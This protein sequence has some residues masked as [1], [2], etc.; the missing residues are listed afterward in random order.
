MPTTIDTHPDLEERSDDELHD[1]LMHID[2]SEEPGRY[3]AAR[4]EFIRRHGASIQ[5]RGVDEY[6]AQ[7]RRRP[8]FA[9]RARFRRKLLIALALWALA[10]LLV[11]AA[12]YVRSVL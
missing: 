9:E 8:T 12:L 3:R 2:R 5:G 4:A 7:A 10:M 11:R 6:L 1:I